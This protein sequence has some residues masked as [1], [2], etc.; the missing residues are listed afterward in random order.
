MAATAATTRRWSI[1]AHP[2]SLGGGGDSSAHAHLP[3]TQRPFDLFFVF[4]FITHVPTSLLVDAQCVLPPGNFPQAARDAL[5]YHLETF[6]DPL[7]GTCPAWLRSIIWCEL[8]LQ[9]PF[10]I[11]A[12][13]AFCARKNWI[14]MVSHETDKKHS[15]NGYRTRALSCA[16]LP[17]FL[18]FVCVCVCVCSKT[19]LID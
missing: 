15:P 2:L 19:T 6:K 8:A 7:M 18:P 12:T 16:F 13:Y 5:A 17:A 14:R 9:V 10:F 1:A 11:L 4:Y 3:L